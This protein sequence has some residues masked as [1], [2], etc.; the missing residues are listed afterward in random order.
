MPCY[1]SLLSSPVF[2]QSQPLPTSSVEK[3]VVEIQA[4]EIVF[5]NILTIATSLAGIAA[6]VVL[7]MGGFKW[8]TSGGD[9]KKME[10]AKG[11]ITYAF[12][13]LACLI[14]IWFVLLFISNF[15]GRPELLKFQLPD[16]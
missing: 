12:V 7:V 6:F 15:T 10:A 13:G 1:L 8:M 11:S 9:P 14:L 4:L 5:S 2:A 16:Q 3:D